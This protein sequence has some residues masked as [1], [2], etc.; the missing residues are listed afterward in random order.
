MIIQI[1]WLVDAHMRPF[2]MI[3]VFFTWLATIMSSLIL[4]P[5][6]MLWTWSK[7][8]EQMVK[9][10]AKDLDHDS[11]HLITHTTVS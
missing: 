10:K 5:V 3:I 2:I 9:M 8:D 1:E 6:I 7:K 11:A 4:D